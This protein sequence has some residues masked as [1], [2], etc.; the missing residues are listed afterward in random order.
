M[1]TKTIKPANLL[2]Y[3]LLI[4]LM[5]LACQSYYKTQPSGNSPSE[6]SSLNSSSRYFIL[7]NND[8]AY[9]LMD[10][11]LS[12][13][14]QS[15]TGKLEYL[16][17]NHLVRLN[18]SKKENYTYSNS[19]SDKDVLN[20][21]HFYTSATLPATI[22][23]SDSVVTV[24]LNQID[25]IE[26]VE[27]DKKRTSHSY[28]IG[29][30]GYSAG[31]LV[32]A[33]IIIAA[34]KSSCPFVIGYN[35]GEFSLQGEIYGGAIYPQLARH[36]Y[37]P[38]KLEPLE[39]KLSVKISNELKELQFTDIANLQVITHLK[40]SRILSDPDGKL[41]SVTNPQRPFSATLNSRKNVLS[42]IRESD[43]DEI[44]YMDDTTSSEALNYV[45]L[46]F[47]KSENSQKGKLILTLKNSYWLDFLYGE[48]AKG[49]G[50]YYNTYLKKQ[51]KKPAAELNKWI[52]DQKIPLQIAV[53]TS[54]GWKT[55]SHINT[56]GPV[57]NR[58]LVIPVNLNDITDENISVK[59]S[60][61]FMFW[62]LDYAAMD[63]T[64]NE[65]FSVKEIHP[66]TAINEKGENVLPKLK[67]ADGI[68]LEQPSP[69]DVTTLTYNY[70]PVSNSSLTQSYILHSK[71]YYQHVRNYQNKPDVDFLKQ[72]TKANAFNLFSK[73]HYKDL[74]GEFLKVLAS[75]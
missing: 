20:E 15:F 29:G 2:I 60:S 31:A 49:F 45:V 36:D 6:I 39:D 22:S 53:K 10:I 42:A 54:A 70:E 61:G 51:S 37:M 73:K 13:D 35:K 4:S 9:H 43:D 24:N 33:G 21:V 48:I 1:K 17:S 57:A 58:D 71:G 46:N 66:A 7:R 50:N 34:T 19:N 75:N 28:L 65:N 25:K 26:V 59:L 41:Y 67:S 27:K 72:F 55:I 52:I 44:L 5:I 74:H 14:Q 16:P 23:G 11:Q 40:T 62:E 47:K 18:K 30:I 8:R 69:G 68:Y 38:L 56:I 3:G 64:D 12:S 63:F 32:L